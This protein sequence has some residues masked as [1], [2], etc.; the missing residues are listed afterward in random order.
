MSQVAATQ[1]PGAPSAGRPAPA[2]PAYVLA[3]W[4]M[5][6]AVFLASYTTWRV[7]FDYL[8]TISD[9]L[10]CVA[11]LLLLMSGRINILPFAG[12]T[13]LWYGALLLMLASLLASSLFYG[14][15]ERWL[16]VAGQYGFAFGLLPMLLVQTSW[17]LTRRLALMLVLGVTA[18]ELFGAAVY[19]VTDHD[20][21][22]AQRFGYEFITGANRLG[23]FTADAN[24]NAAVIA[25][26]LPFTFYLGRIGRLNTIA[27][28][29]C[30]GI[31]ALGLVLTGSVTGFTSA[32]GASAVYLAM[33]GDRKVVRAAM[34]LIVLVVALV[35]VGV[36]DALPDAFEKRVAG[37]IEAGD[38]S[39]AGTYVGRMALIKEAWQMADQTTLLGIGVDQYRVDSSDKM[40]VHNMYLLVWTEG[41]MF[42]LVG[43]L[44]MLTLPLALSFLCLGRDRGAAGMGLAVT[45]VFIGFSVAAPHMYSRSWTVPLILAMSVML[46]RMSGQRPARV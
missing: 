38:M 4:T 32:C 23:A 14:N 10:F 37:A 27:T 34:L 28:A 7:H 26:T 29:S 42:A 17:P 18:M 13:V 21:Q 9:L 20:Y 45:L 5:M 31:L 6:A 11:A 1:R 46:H 39:S 30:V 19:H 35:S 2:S 36:I 41:G 3:G 16:I 15:G 24:W 25:M 44:A 8:F 40:P 33:A 22:T 12:M 43:W